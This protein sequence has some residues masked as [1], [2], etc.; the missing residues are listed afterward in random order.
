MKKEVMTFNKFSICPICH[1]KLGVLK[2]SA[3]GYTLRDTILDGTITDEM[4]FAESHTTLSCPNC[5][6]K[7]EARETLNGLVPADFEGEVYYDND[8]Q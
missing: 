2:F 1:H 4:I 7:V 3:N 6:F 5:K 8:K